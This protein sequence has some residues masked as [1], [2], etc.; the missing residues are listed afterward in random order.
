VAAAVVVL[1][2]F[3][4]YKSKPIRNEK[5]KLVESNKKRRTYKK[6]LTRAQK[7]LSSLGLVSS[8]GS[9]DGRKG[10]GGV[11]VGGSVALLMW[12]LGKRTLF[13]HVSTT[14]VSIS[15]FGKCH[16]GLCPLSRRVDLGNSV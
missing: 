16:S 10:G 6:R 4:C 8:L 5:Y 15:V 13:G 14:F 9:R 1:V 11:E 2:S 12:R 3:R 7:T